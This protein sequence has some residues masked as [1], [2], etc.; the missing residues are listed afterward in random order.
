MIKYS[1]YSYFGNSVLLSILFR[2][3]PHCLFIF[4]LKQFFTKDMHNCTCVLFLS[5]CM[6]SYHI[7]IFLHYEPGP[8]RGKFGPGQTLKDKVCIRSSEIFLMIFKKKFIGVLN[9][10]TFINNDE[11]SIFVEGTFN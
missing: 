9:T 5:C 2:P 1:R 8:Q 6:S 4:I 10:C 7:Q 3:L 11:H